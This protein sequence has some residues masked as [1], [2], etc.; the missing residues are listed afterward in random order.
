LRTP[1]TSRTP[2]SVAAAAAASAVDR[3]APHV[4]VRDGP[5]VVHWHHEAAVLLPLLLPQLRQRSEN[6]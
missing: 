3:V 2:W 1:R 5:R 4:D 6:G